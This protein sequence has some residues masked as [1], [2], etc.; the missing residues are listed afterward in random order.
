MVALSSCVRAGGAVS[1]CRLLNLTDDCGRE[2]QETCNCTYRTVR[3]CVCV[4]VVQPTGPIQKAR[5]Q[6]QVVARHCR[7]SSRLTQSFSISCSK[8]ALALLPSRC[9]VQLFPSKHTHTD[10]HIPVVT[11]VQLKYGPRPK[12]VNCKVFLKADTSNLHS[13]P[14]ALMLHMI[15]DD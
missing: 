3:V 13:C 7:H 8:T 9:R 2:P 4:C 1:V 15:E 14:C 6:Q 11:V 5:P 10:T 12:T